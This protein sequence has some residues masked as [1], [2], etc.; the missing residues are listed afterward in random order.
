MAGI[1][2]SSC[3]FTQKEIISDSNIRTIELEPETPDVPTLELNATREELSQYD[4]DLNWILFDYN[5]D[6]LSNT[7]KLELEK[8][9]LIIDQN[10]NF[11]ARIRAFTDSKGRREYNEKLSARRANQAKQYLISEGISVRNISID[12]YADSKPI[13]LNTEDDTGRRYNR[14]IELFVL[15]NLNNTVCRSHPP[16]IPKSLKVEVQ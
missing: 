12:S 5:S 14:R 3:D 7:A 16:E 6:L 15:D 8:V 4:C 13:A 11:K 9:A 10:S 2:L 1:L